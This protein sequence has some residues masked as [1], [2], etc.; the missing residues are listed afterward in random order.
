MKLLK[1]TL[2]IIGILGLIACTYNTIYNGS[3]T[4]QINGFFSGILLIFASLNLNRL[5]DGIKKNNFPE[6]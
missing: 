1:Y 5:V 4:N 3:I 6:V 2:L